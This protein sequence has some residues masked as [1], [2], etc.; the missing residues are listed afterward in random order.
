[1]LTWR[2][3]RDLVRGLVLC[4]T[5]GRFNGSSR[6]EVAGQRA[7]AGG[8][9]LGS[10][11]PRTVRHQA[12]RQVLRRAERGGTHSWL[13]EQTKRQDLIVG[14]QAIAAIL[15]FDSRSWIGQVDVPTAVVVTEH[16]QLLAPARQRALAHS[17][18]GAV[19]ISC[20]ADHATIVESDTPFPAA[21]VTAIEQ[22]AAATI[23]LPV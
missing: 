10:L 4:A 15:G 3:H 8:S 11:V 21:L 18:V 12:M 5:V 20:P 2:R 9:A 23:S 1:M 7:L 16:D 14:F 13:I 17:I 19:E 6:L 22:V